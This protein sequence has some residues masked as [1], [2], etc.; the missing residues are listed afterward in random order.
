M[1]PSLVTG[2]CPRTS[3]RGI[4]V[5]ASAA[6]PTTVD[7]DQ[8]VLANISGKDD[9]WL[10]GILADGLT[11]WSETGRT[12]PVRYTLKGKHLENTYSRL[13]H[14]TT[15][16][17]PH[18]RRCGTYKHQPCW[19]IHQPHAPPVIAQPAA[20]SIFVAE[21]DLFLGTYATVPVHTPGPKVVVG[22][23]QHSPGVVEVTGLRIDTGGAAIDDGHHAG[24]G[25]G[26]QN[27]PLGGTC[28]GGEPVM[29]QVAGDVAWSVGK[30]RSQKGPEGVLLVNG[31][32]QTGRGNHQGAQAEDGRAEVGRTGERGRHFSTLWEV[33]NGFLWRKESIQWNL[34]GSIDD[35]QV[36]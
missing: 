18:K 3:V 1:R 11:S 36:L 22:D 9:D 25:I 20:Q 21:A 5:Q 13:S 29:H 14:A 27:H 16:L 34:L 7:Q 32:H 23:T 31:T 6:S 17:N 33:G 26:Q 19:N 28:E 8:K 2:L 4:L 12:Q 10:M 15:H 35:E 30:L 24:Q